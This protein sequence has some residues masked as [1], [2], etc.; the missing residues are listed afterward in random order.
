MK[1]FRILFN[2]YRSYLYIALSKTTVMKRWV[3]SRRPWPIARHYLGARLK[4]KPNS[5][6]TQ[7]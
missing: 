5:F 2:N 1:A 4:L 3:D 6:W 7:A